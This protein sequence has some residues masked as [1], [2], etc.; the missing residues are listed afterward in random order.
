MTDTATNVPV[1][2]IPAAEPKAPEE[3]KASETSQ[4]ETVVTPSDRWPL[5]N[6]RREVE[7][8]FDEFYRG[9]W[10]MPFTRT[11]FDVAPIWPG[12]AIWGAVPPVDIVERENDYLIKAEMP[13]VPASK[14]EVRLAEGRLTIKGEKQEEKDEERKG[15]HLS[16]R[17]HGSLQ[18]T[19]RVPDGVDSARIEASFT[20]GVLT[21]TLPKAAEA[22]PSERAI[23]VKAA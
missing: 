1:T 8:V 2:E 16:E 10:R 15:I 14:V 13:G 23:E 20:N 11:A 18:R 4:P 17:R 21:I 22:Q 5:E 7:R 3:A 6:L 9:P 19:F 12:E